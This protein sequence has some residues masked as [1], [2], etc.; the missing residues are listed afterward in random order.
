MFSEMEDEERVFGFSRCGKRR[1]KGGGRTGCFGGF[2]LAVYHKVRVRY[3]LL[4]WF[5][6]HSICY[7]VLLLFYSIGRSKVI[8]NQTKVK[9]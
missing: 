7:Y 3:S 9:Y 6:S 1:R 4:K 8:S 5:Y 2:E